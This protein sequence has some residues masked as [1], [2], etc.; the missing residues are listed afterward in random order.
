MLGF[1]ELPTGGDAQV[2]SPLTVQNPATIVLLLGR[3]AD[4]A[5]VSIT[6]AATCSPEGTLSFD[7]ALW[8]R[9]LRDVPGFSSESECPVHH[10]ERE[11]SAELTGEWTVVPLAAFGLVRCLDPDVEVGTGYPSIPRFV[12]C[13][14]RRLKRPRQPRPYAEMPLPTP[15]MGKR[16]HAA[17]PSTA[18]TEPIAARQASPGMKSQ[19][20]ELKELSGLYLGELAAMLGVSKTAYQGWRASRGIRAQHQEHLLQVL[21]LIREA[22]SRLGGSANA[23]RTWL[24]T[25]LWPG[26]STPLQLAKEQQYRAL[27]GAVLG[28]AE[29][30]PSHR[31]V[32]PSGRTYRPLSPQELEDRLDRLRPHATVEEDGDE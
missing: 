6:G 29:V 8:D 11:A 27:R 32:K 17:A 2:Y 24:R 26:G 3:D 19:A 25:P 15:T 1:L 14:P 7:R 4:L 22:S 12:D 30:Q 20:D 5:A 13:R 9:L 23:V 10:E 16:L 18:Q 21:A 28:I 31:L